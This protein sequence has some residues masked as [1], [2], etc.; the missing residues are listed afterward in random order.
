MKYCRRDAVRHLSV[1]K[2]IG[3]FGI[4]HE[5]GMSL[6]IGHWEYV[7]DFNRLSILPISPFTI[8][9]SREKART[10][11]FPAIERFY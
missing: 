3:H 5:E 2:G 6:G 7:I 9:Q 11:D 8:T 1:E 4:G 10:N